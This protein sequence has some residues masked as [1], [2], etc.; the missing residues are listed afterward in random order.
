LS[1][2]C[3]SCCQ[4]GSP[5]L[6]W[7]GLRPWSL[8]LPPSY[9]PPCPALFWCF[10]QRLLV[11]TKAGFHSTEVKERLAETLVET[12]WVMASHGVT[13]PR[14]QADSAGMVQAWVRLDHNV[15]GKVVCWWASLFGNGYDHHQSS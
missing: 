6:A 9:E 11:L 2:F 14:W 10:S 7:S 15:L 3:F 1:P 12:Q 13:S 8:P 5:A 4:I